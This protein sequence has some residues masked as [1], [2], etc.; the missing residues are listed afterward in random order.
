MINNVEEMID[1]W[2]RNFEPKPLIVRA[3][4]VNPRQRGQAQWTMQD[5]TPVIVLADDLVGDEL[6]K[7]AS[8]EAAHILCKH[9]KAPQPSLIRR[10]LITE[11]D[12]RPW[13][14]HTDEQTHQRIEREAEYRASMLRFEW[15]VERLLKYFKGEK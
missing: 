14:R 1:F 12:Y 2:F 7:V 5:A 4:F 3:K 8:H 11:E 6:V 9:I 15:N 13:R 10:Q